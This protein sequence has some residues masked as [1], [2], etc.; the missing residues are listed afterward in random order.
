MFFQ[1]LTVATVV[2]P[3]TPFHLLIIVRLS[4]LVPCKFSKSAAPSPLFTPRRISAPAPF[5]NSSQ[6]NHKPAGSACHKSKSICLLAYHSTTFQRKY[7][8]KQKHN[9]LHGHPRHPPRSTFATRPYRFAEQYALAFSIRSVARFFTIVHEPRCLPSTLIQ[10]PY[11]F[12][13]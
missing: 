1:S 11:R 4:P 5:A 8:K 13:L 6:M 9:H 12:A 3:N 7:N 10:K 2:L